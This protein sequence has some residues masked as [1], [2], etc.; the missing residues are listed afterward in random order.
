LINHLAFVHAT[1]LS[2]TF[3]SFWVL[4]HCISYIIIDSLIRCRYISL[5]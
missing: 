2:P 4:L 3:S 5:I 1:E